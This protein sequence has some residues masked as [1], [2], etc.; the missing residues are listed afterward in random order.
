MIKIYVNHIK[1]FLRN[2]GIFLVFI[3]FLLT[4]NRE[5]V[6]SFEEGEPSIAV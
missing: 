4:C 1:F 5:V 6:M 2:K 3:G